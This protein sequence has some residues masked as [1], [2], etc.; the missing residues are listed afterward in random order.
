MHED[1]IKTPISGISYS[2]AMRHSAAIGSLSTLRD[3]IRELEAQSHPMFKFAAIVDFCI[4][5][6]EFETQYG[7]D[8][9]LDLEHSTVATLIENRVLTES[10][11]D[12]IRGRQNVIRSDPLA[13]ASAEKLRAEGRFV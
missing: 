6:S 11:V 7:D 4:R 2:S 5:A 13:C 1:E 8:C 10:K 9:L 3:M 12:A